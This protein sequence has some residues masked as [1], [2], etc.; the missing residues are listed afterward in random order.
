[1]ADALLLAITLKAAVEFDDRSTQC[2]EVSSSA[3]E[4]S[5]D[6]AS[7]SDGGRDSSHVGWKPLG[8]RLAKAV[9][10]CRKHEDAADGEHIIVAEWCSVGTRLSKTLGKCLDADRDMESAHVE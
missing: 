4:C 8:S 6:F 9:E 5:Y 2:A 3:S 7:D 10:S 1:M